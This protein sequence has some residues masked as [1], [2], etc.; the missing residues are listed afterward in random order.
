MA[1]GGARAGA[2]R[3][4]NRPAMYVVDGGAPPSEAAG[5]AAI[6]NDLPADQA[7]VWQKW[8]PLATERRTLTA[9]TVPAFTLLCELEAEKRAVKRTLDHDGRTYVKVV[10]D[11]AGQEHQELKAH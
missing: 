2:G 4:P 9:Q 6:P 11:G 5:S 3:K 10:I 7:L 8:A 1:R